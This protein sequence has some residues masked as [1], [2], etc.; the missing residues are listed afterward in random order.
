[1]IDP[2]KNFARADVS[3]G[4]ADDATEIV[5]ASGHGDRFPAPAEDGA[6]NLVWWNASDYPNPSDDPDVEIVRCTARSGDTLTITR[7]QEG[8]SAVN[9][10]T[11]GKTYRII[12]GLTASVVAQI[13][14]NIEALEGESYE[15]Q[16]EIDDHESRIYELEN[17]GGGGIEPATV[18][19]YAGASAPTGYLLCDGASVSRAT[20]AA[21]FAIIGTTYGSADGSTFNVPNL[22]GRVIVGFDSAQTEFD[23]LGETGGAKTHTLTTTEMPAHSHTAEGGSFSGSAG[24]NVARSGNSALTI[25][26]S[27]AGSGGAHNNLQPY[28]ALNYIIK[29]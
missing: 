6:F 21:L 7:A 18:L 23:T 29:T 25:T 11:S 5:L 12:L 9:H 19:P 20:Y 27:S 4:Y 22:K 16:Q 24:S 15:Q 14:E 26:T 2:A 1:M 17:A 10:N 3:E 8:T 13:I 28:M